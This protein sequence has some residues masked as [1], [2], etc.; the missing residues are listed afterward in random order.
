[1]QTWVG[2]TQIQPGQIKHTQSEDLQ[3][4]LYPNSTVDSNLEESRLS[5]LASLLETGRTR[6]QLLSPADI[7]RQR[8]EKLVWNAAWNST[9]A[10]TMVDTQTWLHSSPEATSSTRRIMREVI[11]VGRARGVKLE[12]NLIDKLVD[13]ILGMP[14]IGSSMQTDCKNGRPLEIDVIL[15]VPVKKA[16]EL[17]METP[18]LEMVYALVKAVDTRLRANI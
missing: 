6:F 1:M 4:G 16:R 7:Q 14:G 17:G 3:I 11:D 2:A 8:W 15:G 9:T 13:K 10:L 5:T 18:T 12:Y